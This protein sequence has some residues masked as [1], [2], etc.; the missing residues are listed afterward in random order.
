MAADTTANGVPDPELI[1]GGTT[2]IVQKYNYM[3]THLLNPSKNLQLGR[4][5]VQIG[6]TVGHRYGTT[7]R[8]VSDTRT[9]TFLLE[10]ADQVQDLESL[11]LSG[12]V[13]N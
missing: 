6:S 1:T 9:K 13:F 12:T 4:D 10:V 8:M 3:R 11:F 5:L 2:V 7:F